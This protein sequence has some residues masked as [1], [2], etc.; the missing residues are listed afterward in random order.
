MANVD[1]GALLPCVSHMVSILKGVAFSEQPLRCVGSLM[2]S[3][4]YFGIH[5]KPA[6]PDGGEVG[7]EVVVIKGEMAS[8]G[9][10]K[11]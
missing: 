10:H 5:R 6:N 8:L 3:N 4:M 1:M 11:G 2:E 7:V 9:R